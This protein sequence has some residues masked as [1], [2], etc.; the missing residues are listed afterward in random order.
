[1]LRLEKRQSIHD[2]VN[3]SV[4]SSPVESSGLVEFGRSSFS[5]IPKGCKTSHDSHQLKAVDSQFVLWLLLAEYGFSW[6]NT[7][8]YHWFL[9]NFRSAETLV[10]ELSPP[11][12]N[13]L[14]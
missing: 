10:Y 5:G 9:V 13:I 7:S 6:Q 4:R 8:V 1:M 14:L 11:L 12:L 2:G 3:E